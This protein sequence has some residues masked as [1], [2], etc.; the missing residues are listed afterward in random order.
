MTQAFNAGL[1]GTVSQLAWLPEI[2]I[3]RLDADQ[4]LQTLVANGSLFGFTHVTTACITPNVAPFTCQDPDEFL[5]WDGI[6]PT[7]AVHAII[8]NEAI[9]VLTP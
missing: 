2:D 8:A 1:D 9:A 7:R 6:H 3:V 4:L 5:F